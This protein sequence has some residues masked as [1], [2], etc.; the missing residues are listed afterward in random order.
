MLGLY[1]YNIE[2]RSRD[3][4][5]TTIV[6]VVFGLYKLSICILISMLFFIF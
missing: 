2:L 6:E 3:H 5:I 4:S 1:N